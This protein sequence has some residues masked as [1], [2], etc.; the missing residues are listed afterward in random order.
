[1]SWLVRIAEA[2]YEPLGRHLHRGD[3]DEHAAF[4]FAGHVRAGNDDRL[5]VHRVV[6]VADAE[7]GPSDRGGY[8]QVSARA[9]A[10]AAID[11]EAHG[12]RLL[13]AHNHPGA[14]G[15]VAFSEPDRATHERAHPHMIEMTG[16]RPVGSLVFGTE[17]AAGEIW[18]PDGTRSALERLDVVGTRLARLTAS[19]RDA[20]PSADRFDRQVRMFG[21]AGQAALAA[22][23][24]AVVGAGGGGSLI[25]QALAHLGVGHIVV[26]DFDRVMATNLSRIVGARPRDA[27]RRRLKVDVMRR[28][29]RAIDPTITVTTQLGDVTYTQDARALV[30]CDF[31][32]SAT[33]TQFA[34]YAVNALCHQYL[35]PGAQ[36]GAKVLSDDR[37]NIRLAYVAYR[38]IDL[39]GAC[40]ECGGAID[41]DALRREQL[42]TAERHA[43]NYVD[44]PAGQDLPDPS[45]ITLN[46]MAVSL[47][48]LDFQFAATGMTER[49]THL[50]QRIYHAP[51]RA[52]RT[53]Q[54]GPRPACRWCDRGL[55]DAAFGR[56]DDH[57]LPLRPGA[58][59]LG[60]ARGLSAWP[61][62]RRGRG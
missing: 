58:S 18:H 35:I 20:A 42:S 48:M 62:R 25:T 23:K 53:R 12:L 3:G 22:M 50:E 7:F 59:E 44:A 24:V 21:R 17:S 4:L 14:T 52:L 33:D 38:P 26:V 19:P 54:V 15:R 40:L 5:L 60:R 28:L 37:G 45:V 34:R 51:E 56:G 10:R 16:G 47:A 6:P 27:R 1:M 39:G 36:V 43:Q 9:V 49:G 13:W 32:F 29:V 61:P 8:R 57:V 46:S 41:A 55:H 30:N 2:D 31:I 11:C